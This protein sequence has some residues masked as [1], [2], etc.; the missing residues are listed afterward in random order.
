[1]VDVDQ[2]EEAPARPPSR[3]RYTNI[4]RT[5]PEPAVNE[6]LPQQPTRSRYEGSDALHRLVT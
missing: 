4:E 5:T 6:I 3:N 2:D 1:M